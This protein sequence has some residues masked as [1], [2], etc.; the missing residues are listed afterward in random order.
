MK[1][2]GEIP[3][4]S[5]IRA[6]AARLGYRI[7]PDNPPHIQCWTCW[8]YV[9][10]IEELQLLFDNAE[11]ARRILPGWMHPADFCDAQYEGTI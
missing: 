7:T 11:P 1:K 9:E 4:E 3:T 2:S 10:Q 6:A 5:E 8:D